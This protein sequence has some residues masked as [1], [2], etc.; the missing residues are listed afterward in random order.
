[1]KSGFISFIGRPNVGKSTLLNMF[2]GHKIA[3][4]SPTA[5]TTRTT[6]QGIKTSERGQIIVVDTPGI[7]KPQDALGHFMNGVAQSSS[8]GVDIAAILLPADESVGSGDEFI[9][10]Q[11][12]ALGGNTKKIAIISKIDKVSKEKLLMKVMR[13]SDKFEFDAIIPVSAKKQEN[14]DRLEDAIFDMLPEAPLYYDEDTITIQSDTFIVKEF[15]R[16][17]IFHLTKEEIPHAVAVIIDQWE[18]TKDGLE[19][20]ASIIVERKSQKAIIIGKQG[21][22]IKEIRKQAERDLKRH[23]KEKVFLELWV[24]VEKN[25][26]SNPKYLHEFGYD[27]KDYK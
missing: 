24:K 8:E 4:M 21:S 3:I 5:Q 26:R 20:T 13:L 6:I 9:M 15:I 1:M 14:L 23:F 16:E 2:I 7:H 17:K 18:Q 11:M 10:E 22:M 27:I 12:N 25:W 19:I